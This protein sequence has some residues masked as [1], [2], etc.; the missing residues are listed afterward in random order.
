[1]SFISLKALSYALLPPLN[2]L[3]L[4]FL[5]LLILS[6][7]RRTGLNLIIVSLAGLSLLS[8][9][10]VGGFLTAGIETTPPGPSATLAHSQAIVILGAGSYPEAPEY[11][12]D[13]VSWASLERVRWGARLHRLS[14]LPIMVSGGSPFRTRT[15]EAAQMA[16]V[17]AQDFM[18]QAKWLDEKSLNTFESA[19]N[20]RNQFSELKIERIVLVTHALHMRRARWVFEQAGFQVTEAA[21]GF[22]TQSPPSILNYLPT[23]HGLEASRAALHE[24]MGIGWYHLRFAAQAQKR[25]P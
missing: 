24:M 21:T 11:G 4:G 9:P 12:G 25:G 3:L 8:T 23:S 22:S 20:A 6:V 19:L 1:M 10:V 13:T 2:L 15:S 16:A 14:G 5:G 17:L 7:R 18:V